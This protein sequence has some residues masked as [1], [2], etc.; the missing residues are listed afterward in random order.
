[1]QL[2]SHRDSAPSAWDCLNYWD[3]SF[4][5]T[6]RHQV[7]PSSIE[8]LFNDFISPR[9]SQVQF[10]YEES[11]IVFAFWL[12][13]SGQGHFSTTGCKK[14]FI[15]LKPGKAAIHYVPGVLGKTEIQ[16]KQ[17]YRIF[18]VYVSPA[19]L[20]R[21]IENEEYLNAHELIAVLSGAEPSPYY[22][23]S[24]MSTR[25]SRI[26]DQI[27]SCPYCGAYRQ[28]Y[29]ENKSMELI[30]CRLEEHLAVNKR[31]NRVRLSSRDV[32]RIHEAKQII[33]SNL[34]NPPTLRELGR[35]V[36]INTSK[37]NHGFRQV[38]GNTVHTLLQQERLQRAG[39]LL[40]E[41][42]MNITEISQHLGFSDASHFVRQ[43]SREYGISPGKFAKKQHYNIPL[44]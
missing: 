6:S 1:M 27:Y 40:A 14:S 23:I 22:L 18:S 31:N 30:L 43:F 36:G 41:N 37:L 42:R 21:F 25:V 7:L 20:L 3:Q 5:S 39:L 16:E 26:L 32:E 19:W 2:A 15:E 28:M 9:T 11:P 24:D 10:R 34:E 17:Y 35:M 4:P 12:S 38:Y 29:L 44:T 13:G 8:L 33:S